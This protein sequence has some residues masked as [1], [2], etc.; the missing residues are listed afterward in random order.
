MKDFKETWKINRTL[1]H[2]EERAK[3]FCRSVGGVLY[4]AYGDK[5]NLQYEIEYDTLV[6]ENVID[7]DCF[8]YLPYMVVWT[9]TEEEEPEEDRN[10]REIFAFF[11]TY[12]EAR[13]RLNNVEDG[14]IYDK[15]KVDTFNGYLLHLRMLNEQQRAENIACRYCV[16]YREYDE[17]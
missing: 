15:N 1:F 6:A 5:T 13:E 8:N 16:A 9:D 17:E 7:S 3:A 14:V 2:E 12:E 10:Y 4:W 11:D